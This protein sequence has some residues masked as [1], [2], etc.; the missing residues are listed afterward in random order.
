MKIGIIGLGVVGSAVFDGLNQLG[1]S[2]YYFDI[3][4]QGSI[5]QDILSTDLVF[6]CVPTETVDDYCDLSQVY[7]TERTSNKNTQNVWTK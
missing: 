5:L 3:S 7:S 1:H 6:I 2:M 4:R